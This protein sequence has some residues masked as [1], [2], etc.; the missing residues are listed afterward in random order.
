MTP[1]TNKPEEVHAD[2]W[3]PHDRP[4]QSESVYAAILIFEHTRNTNTFYLQGKNDFV[5]AFQASLPRVKAESRCYMK[6]LRVDGGGG[7]ISVKLR[8]F[9]EKRG[10]T[11][12]YAA[13]YIYEEN[14]LAE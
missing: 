2:L 11:I 12:R 3:G 13:P 6:I 1:T 14:R 4:S 10:I 8:L 7:F 9:F 5:D